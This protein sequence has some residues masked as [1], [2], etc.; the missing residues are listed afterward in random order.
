[1]TR[2][3][4]LDELMSLDGCADDPGEGEWFAASSRRTPSTSSGGCLLLHYRARP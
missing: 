2:N 1:M 4:V 3:V